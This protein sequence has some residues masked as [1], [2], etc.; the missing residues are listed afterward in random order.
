MTGNLLF[1]GI[2]AAVVGAII[3]H[4]LV[5]AF[6]RARKGQTSSGTP[7][8]DLEQKANAPAT[9]THRLRHLDMLHEEVTSPS[10]T[11]V[12]TWPR[13]YNH[14]A[15]DTVNMSLRKNDEFVWQDLVRCP[16]HGMVTDEGTVMVVK[17]PTEGFRGGVRLY[18][19]HGDLMM[20]IDFKSGIAESGIAGNQ[21]FVWCVVSPST[22]QTMTRGRI[23]L[24]GMP[25]CDRIIAFPDIRNLR[26][27]FQGRILDIHVSEFHAT[28]YIENGPKVTCD[29]HG[30]LVGASNA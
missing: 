19:T 4:G 14:T 1:L 20:E 13:Q 26:P 22:G 2:A 30:N 23:F 8:L 17:H 7:K 24:F 15:D 28:L 5:I 3:A 12:L 9:S 6:L 18:D 10:G 16:G 21:K 25:D 29:F 11:Y 27:A